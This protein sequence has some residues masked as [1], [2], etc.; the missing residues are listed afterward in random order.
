MANGKDRAA[1]ASGEDRRAADDHLPTVA[2][3]QFALG[4][5]GGGAS[6]LQR[7]VIAREIFLPRD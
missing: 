1:S 7:L 4:F 3:Q 5:V 6:A 2:V